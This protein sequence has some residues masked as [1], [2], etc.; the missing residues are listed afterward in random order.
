MILFPSEFHSPKDIAK[1]LY[2]TSIWSG[3]RTSQVWM[4]GFNTLRTHVNEISRSPSRG[5]V[6]GLARQMNLLSGNTETSIFLQPD[7]ASGC[8]ESCL[9]EASALLELGYPRDEPGIFTTSFPSPG[10]N[11]IRTRHHIRSAVHHLGGDFELLRTL[12]RTEDS[13]SASLNVS[14]AVWPLQRVPEDKIVLRLG[15]PGQTVPSIMIIDTRL[16]GYSV[17]CCWDLALRLR[18]TE[19]IPTSEPDFSSFAADFLQNR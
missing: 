1:L 4:Q 19:N 12:F 18:D 9:V 17:L 11:S 2:Y 15:Y 5:R 3:G 16:L 10:A 8:F 6:E 13:S 7:I 14:F